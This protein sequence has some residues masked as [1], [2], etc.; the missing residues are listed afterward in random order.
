MNT[1]TDSMNVLRTATKDSLLILVVKNGHGKRDTLFVKVA[2]RNTTR[3]R[4]GSITLTLENATRENGATFD[5]LVT[6]NNYDNFGVV[7]V[8]RVLDR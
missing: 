2:E 5:F 3:G 8:H 7:S 4:T 1:R 6:D